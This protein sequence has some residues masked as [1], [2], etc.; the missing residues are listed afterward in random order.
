MQN[1]DSILKVLLITYGHFGEDGEQECENSQVDADPL[2]SESLSQILGHRKD[3]RQIQTTFY[4]LQRFT[5]F[6]SR[7]L[8]RWST[9]AK[10]RGSN[11][12]KFR[13]TS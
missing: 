1:K 10:H 2:T 12:A 5:E 9:T 11:K 7:H 6:H 3:L 13:M 4:D 8:S